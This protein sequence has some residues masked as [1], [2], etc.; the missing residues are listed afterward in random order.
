MNRIE[1]SRVVAYCLCIPITD[2]VGSELPTP[3]GVAYAALIPDISDYFN[4]N[5]TDFND[6]SMAQ[7]ILEIGGGH[8]V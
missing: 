2:F 4:N 7:A 3:F 6:Y 1:A 5:T 8:L